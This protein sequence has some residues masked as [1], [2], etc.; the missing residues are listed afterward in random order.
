LVL[1]FCYSF[2]A[3]YLPHRWPT[4]NRRRFYMACV[5]LAVSF[6]LLADI[7]AY[8]KLGERRRIVLAGIEH[9]RANPESNSPLNDP[10]LE[11]GFENEEVYERDTLTRAIQQHLYTLP[12]K[13][14]SR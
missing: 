2:L 5:L 10:N 4:F 13:Q 1:I 3:E 6:C 8:K 12:P 9:Y 14:E 11:T 7:H